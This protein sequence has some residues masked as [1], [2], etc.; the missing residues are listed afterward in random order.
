MQQ[1][2]RP[3]RNGFVL[4]TAL[5]VTMQGGAAAA[6]AAAAGGGGGGGVGP[7]INQ[8]MLHL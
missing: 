6:A 4:S 2:D 7:G 3:Q 5:C 1:C 8:S